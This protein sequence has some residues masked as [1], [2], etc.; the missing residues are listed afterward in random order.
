MG[1]S[2]RETFPVSFTTRD[3]FRYIGTE[4]VYPRSGT[5]LRA[6]RVYEADAFRVALRAIAENNNSI[7]FRRTRRIVGN[8]IKILRVLLF[9]K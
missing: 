1:C 4:R 3:F 8:P 9:K 6:Q 5:L 7:Y 2:R